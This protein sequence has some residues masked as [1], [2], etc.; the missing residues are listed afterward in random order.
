M[1]EVYFPNWT[2]QLGWSAV[3]ARTD[4]L[5]GHRAITVYY[6]WRGKQLAYTIVDGTLGQPAGQNTIV[7]DTP[8]RT[9][10]LGG[11]PGITW[12]EAG[13]TCILLALSGNGVN[14]SRL[15]KL[16]GSEVSSAR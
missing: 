9:F 2:S 3:G 13:D 10:V 6:E 12:R 16:A 11:R 5:N 14:S 7:Q 1:G 8:M 4:N 15:E